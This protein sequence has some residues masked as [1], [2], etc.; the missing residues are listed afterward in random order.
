M[1][2]SS[3]V[4]FPGHSALEGAQAV[5]GW[6]NEPATGGCEIRGVYRSPQ[7]FSRATS[8]EG[9]HYASC[10]TGLIRHGG[11]SLKPKQ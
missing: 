5:K 10:W 1:E 6:G 11:R 4:I 3:P 7:I 8:D 9:Q 2:K